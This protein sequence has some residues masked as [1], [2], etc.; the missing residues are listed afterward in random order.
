MASVEG[1]VEIEEV[2]L[3]NPGALAKVLIDPLSGVD[4]AKASEIVAQAKFPADVADQVARFVSHG[5]PNKLVAF[6]SSRER[7]LSLAATLP[8]NLAAT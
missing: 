2:A 8:E 6:E 1:G 3:N 5:D 4:T 7:P